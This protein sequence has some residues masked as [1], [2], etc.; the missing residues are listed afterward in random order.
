ME[1]GAGQGVTG[2]EGIRMR[3]LRRTLSKR[4]STASKIGRRLSFQPRLEALEDRLLPATTTL[5]V[6]VPIGPTGSATAAPV[7]SWNPVAGADAY[8]I[9]VVD[10]TTQKT[11]FGAITPQTSYA[12]PAALTVGDTYAWSV[13]AQDSNNDTSGQ[14]A[15]LTFTVADL[16]VPTFLSPS[17]AATTTPT[18]I[19][20]A[21]A[22]A[23]KYNLSL[24]DQTTG[25]NQQIT[26]L[27]TTSW[28]PGSPLTLQ[29][30]YVWM[31]QGVDSSNA[32]E[33]WSK[34]HAFVVT[35]LAAPTPVRP[36]GTATS[37]LPVLTWNAVPGT[38]HYDFW[39]LEQDTTQNTTATLEYTHVVGTTLTTSQF[40]LQAGLTYSWKVRAVDS[41]NHAGAWSNTL[42][43]VVI[44]LQAPTL[45]GP[46]NASVLQPTFIWNTLSGASK[47]DIWVQDER[48]G[49]ILRDQA[50]TG[51]SWTPS[52]PLTLGDTYDWWVRGIDIDGNPGPWSDAASF[53]VFNL[54]A[55]TLLSTSGSSTTP[56]AFHWNAVTGASDYDIWVQDRETGQILRDQAVTGTSWTPS[57]PLNQGDTYD[58]WVRGIDGNHV[59][60]P[61]S[62]RSTL[63]V[64]LYPAPGLIAPTGSSSTLPTFS[65][66]PGF[67]VSPKY[68]IWVQD[69]QT[70]QVLRDQSVTT[71]RSIP[72]VTW[73]P[74][75][76]LNQGDT[77][78][79]WVRSVDAD[80][81]P[82]PWSTGQTFTVTPLATPSLLGPSGA[83]VATLPT[84]SWGAVA[85]ASHYDIWV[86]PNGS[87]QVL[88]NQDVTGT[89]WTPTTALTRGVGYTWWVRAVDSVNSPGPW[90]AGQTFTVYALPAP[91]LIG[92]SGATSS[93]PTFSWKAVTGADHYDIY[94][95]DMTTG[96]VLRKTNVTGTTAAPTGPLQKGDTYEWWVRAVTSTGLDGIWSDPLELTVTT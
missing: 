58:W 36:S 10:L 34:T 27:T 39:A 26:G 84:F 65:W 83:I 13:Q 60:G 46:S 94:V 49:Q 67:P 24:T 15:P 66:G 55:P 72:P 19:W 70:G 20:N 93:L 25:H 7:F 30:T 23:L 12:P 4:T 77:Y 81:S 32:A 57:G 42:T 16:D 5:A 33:P 35:N 47:Y 56:L 18:F 6:P 45:D 87:S 95:E 89:T 61:W 52:N 14:S 86:Q 38:D 82:G 54:A 71:P 43:F 80:G 73:T 22:G 44:P 2:T 88:R 63:S 85:G 68:D 29:H 74:S 3:W 21:A 40:P 75:S 78:D 8:N 50:V 92:P 37:V 48:T 11:G 64:Q 79:W 91:T 51:T 53:T 9:V 41:A 90:S 69:R 17:D 62:N 96:Q 59:P 1:Q 28:T 76:P 31:V